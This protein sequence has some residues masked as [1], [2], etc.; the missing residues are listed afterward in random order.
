MRSQLVERFGV[1]TPQIVRRPADVSSEAAAEEAIA[2]AN[3][4]GLCDGFPLDD[5]QQL[6]LRLAMAERADGSWAAATIG[7]FEPRQSGKNDTVA[8]RELFGLVVGGE[9]LIIHTAH[10]FPTA[11][12]SFL[13]FV[14]LFEAW[15]ALRKKVRRVYY[16]AGTQGVTFMNGARILYKTRTGGAGR[17]F[18]KADLGGYDEAQHLRVEHVAASGPAR[19]A[20]PNAQAWYCGSGGLETSENTWRLRRRALTGEGAPRFAYVEHTAERVSVVDGRIVCER[21]ADVLDR[22]HWA[23]AN[24]AYGHRITDESLLSLYDELGPELFA[25]ECLCVW[26][27]EPGEDAQVIPQAAW[28]LV[29][30]S[31]VAPSG[32]LV[33]AVDVGEERDCAAI[34]AV[35]DGREIEVVD[36][37][38]LD[39]SRSVRSGLAWL[40][41]RIGELNDR[42]K[43]PLWAFDS[44]GPVAAV[45]D[46]L[47][48]ALKRR[49]RLRPLSGPELLLACGQFFDD[50]A[51]ARVRVR[52][53][54]ALD[55]AVAGASRSFAG[56][57]WRFVRKDS[58]SDITA[59]M[60][61]TVGLWAAS[62]DVPKPRIHTLT[63]KEAG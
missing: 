35:S 62:L 51:D 26:D 37:T 28:N 24:P 10:E 43:R 19:L 32:R 1:Q 59:L 16:G 40:S 12:E 25:R 22:D 61:A 23:T 57:R 20:N 15:D 54:R 46:G 45:V 50:V 11:N 49:L 38:G 52:R 31:D 58:S 21:P 55:V 27:P 48:P 9:Q 47:E 41:G 56:D 30:G 5:S 13:R 44:T 17:G 39:R 33:F 7:D 36:A 42:W 53:D 8:A 3:A 63:A 29:C 6:T 14:G 34:V 18:A 4:Y 60:A 2:L